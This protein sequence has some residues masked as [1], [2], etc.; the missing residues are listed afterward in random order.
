MK[1]IIKKITDSTPAFEAYI[2]GK[3]LPLARLIKSFEKDGEAEIL[4][5]I[6]RTSRHHGKGEEV[7]MAAADLRLPKKVI[8]A[9]EC[10]SSMRAAV[11]RM[12]D[13]LKLEIEKYK[14][15]FVEINRKKLVKD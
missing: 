3:L 15:Q 8:R 10:A 7:F 4:L 5:N 2:D 12:R 11:D 6:V 9:E 13:T 1:I 14:T